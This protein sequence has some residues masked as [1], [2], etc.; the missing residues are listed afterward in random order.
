MCA[1]CVQEGACERVLAAGCAVCA[2]EGTLQGANGTGAGLWRV[3]CTLLG[4]NGTSKALILA[5]G[6]PKEAPPHAG[7]GSTKAPPAQHDSLLVRGTGQRHMV[8][9]RSMI[10]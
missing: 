8:V 3:G 4:A 5:T 10:N 2:Q 6:L 1:V 7:P 9:Q